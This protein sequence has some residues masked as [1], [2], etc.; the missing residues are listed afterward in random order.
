MRVFSKVKTGEGYTM[1]ESVESSPKSIRTSVGGAV[2]V[3][4]QDLE[5]ST[6]D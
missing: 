6:S 2:E 3:E 4:D 1:L 5:H